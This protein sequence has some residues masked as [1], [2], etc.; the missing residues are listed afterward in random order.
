M[1]KGI[2]KGWAVDRLRDYYNLERDEVMAFGDADNDREM[3]LHAGWP[4]PKNG[5]DH[6]KQIAR[7]IAPPTIRAPGGY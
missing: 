3:L 7:I 6:M 1:C 2:D 4:S 5:T